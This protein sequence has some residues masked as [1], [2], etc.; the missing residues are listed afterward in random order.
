MT[1]TYLLQQRLHL[2]VVVWEAR[3]YL[4]RLVRPYEIQLKLQSVLPILVGFVADIGAAALP[5]LTFP[6]TQLH[7]L[8][9]Q[10]VRLR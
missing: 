5:L 1:L 2:R 7:T 10:Q 6:N 3:R 9:I 8:A 4:G